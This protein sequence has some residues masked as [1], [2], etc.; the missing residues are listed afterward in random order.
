M[1]NFIAT[2]T[3][4]LENHISIN[5][6]TF[7]NKIL[8]YNKAIKS[9]D[10]GVEFDYDRIDGETSLFEYFILELY[11]DTSECDDFDELYHIIMKS[12]YEK[13][14]EQRRKMRE[15]ENK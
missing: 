9:M 1:N 5:F 3:N 7:Q 15:K 2:E 12:A 11:K 14:N 6:C 8:V 10:K 13:M 4:K